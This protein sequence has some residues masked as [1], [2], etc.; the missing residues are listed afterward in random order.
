MTATAAPIG[1]QAPTRAVCVVGPPGPEKTAL[2]S[3]LAGWLAGRG[4]RVAV[5][6]LEAPGP[7]P[8]VGKDTGRFRRAGARLAALAAPG[9]LQLTYADPGDPAFPSLTQA[10]DL[11]RPLADLTLV[12]GDGRGLPRVVLF[13]PGSP[14]P[15]LDN[16]V[17]WAVVGQAPTA[18]SGPVFS[19]EEMNALGQLLLE[20]W[21]LA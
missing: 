7:L 18:W 2:L 21:E 14:A 1:S 9:W 20:R 5:L 10:L 4:F 12:D 17:V 15:C 19:S 16:G 3:R 13:L 8:D 6:C 11:L